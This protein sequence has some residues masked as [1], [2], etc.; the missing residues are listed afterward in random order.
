MQ[1]NMYKNIEQINADK[2][3]IKRQSLYI[4]Y[5]KNNKNFYLKFYFG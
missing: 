4:D 5:F 1:A 3:I 2:K